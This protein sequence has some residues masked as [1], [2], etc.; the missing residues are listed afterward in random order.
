MSRYLW[1]L[2]NGHGILQGDKNN[3]RK[4]YLLTERLKHDQPRY[5]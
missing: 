5:I 3:R 2:D 1:L 4:R